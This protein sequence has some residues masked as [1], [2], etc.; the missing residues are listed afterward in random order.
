MEDRVER[1]T[2]V[3]YKPYSARQPLSQYRDHSDGVWE[4]AT[5]NLDTF[6]SL[7]ELTFPVL[8]GLLTLSVFK[9]I[10][11]TALHCSFVR[12]FV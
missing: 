2:W 7:G 6:L 11:K 5:A 12:G 3:F 8:M 1:F 10:F 9:Y 4:D